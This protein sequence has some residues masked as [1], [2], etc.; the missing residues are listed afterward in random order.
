[1]TTVIWVFGHLGDGIAACA[2]IGIDHF[3]WNNPIL[4][5]IYTT[6]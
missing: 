2:A 1:L 3:D 4:N 6:S 5:M